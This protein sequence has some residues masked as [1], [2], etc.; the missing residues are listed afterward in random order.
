[1][2]RDSGRQ[3]GAGPPSGA[4]LRR[5]PLSRQGLGSC[6]LGSP[7]AAARQG[8]RWPIYQATL[9]AVAGVG[10]SSS[11][12]PPARPTEEAHS[13]SRQAIKRMETRDGVSRQLEYLL[14]NVISF[15]VPSPSP[16]LPVTPPPSC[17][18]G[19]Q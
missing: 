4:H 5:P 10:V 14:K 17:S 7:R 16:S 1:M 18:T 2:G 3:R 19:W 15:Y 11:P 8:E 13:L 12:L 6:G 9:I